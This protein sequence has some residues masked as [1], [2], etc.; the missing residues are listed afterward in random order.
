MAE[1]SQGRPPSRTEYD[2]KYFQEGEM[3]IYWPIGMKA[4]LELTHE[5][6]EEVQRSDLIAKDIELCPKVK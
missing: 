4:Y 2:P 6:P 1:Q 5:P 3:W